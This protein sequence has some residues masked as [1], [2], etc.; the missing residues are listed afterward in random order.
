MVRICSAV[1]KAAAVDHL[2][3]KFL[4][5]SH[6]RQGQGSTAETF[7]QGDDIGAYVVVLTREP[8]TRAAHTGHHLVLD[9]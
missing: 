9:E 6:G 4:P 2:N 1:R 5:D 3:V 7:A 8:F